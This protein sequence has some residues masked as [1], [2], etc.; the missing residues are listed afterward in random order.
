[1]VTIELGPYDR[2]TEVAITRAKSGTSQEEAGFIVDLVREFREV[3]N[4][5]FRPSIR[6]CMMIAK[7]TRSRGGQVQADDPIFLETCL[8]ILGSNATKMRRSNGSSRP[9]VTSLSTELETG[10]STRLMT[11]L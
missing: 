11:G 8:D 3:E 4:A 2:E 10:P 7:V 6:A 1:M 9:V 5:R